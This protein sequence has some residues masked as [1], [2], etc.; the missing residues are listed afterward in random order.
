M[1][2]IYYQNLKLHLQK[3]GYQW[4]IDII[5]KGLDK[6]CLDYG[7]FAWHC[8]FVIVNSGMKNQ[9]AEMIYKKIQDAVKN[10]ISISNVFGHA[11]KVKAIEF[12]IE[13]RIDLFNKF[14]SV[15]IS[16]KISYLETIPFIGGITKYHLARN[17]GIDV[18]KPDRHLERIAKKYKTTPEILCKKLSDETGDRVGI[19]DLII[20]RSANLGLF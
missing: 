18:C 13:N 2:K 1:N 14:L 16:E 5:Q 15:Q 9:I 8:I 20:W 10:N 3:I 19:V 6:P 17:L 11:G 4:E 12:I 7:E